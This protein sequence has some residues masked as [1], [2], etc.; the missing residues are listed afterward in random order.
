MGLY[1]DEL[2]ERLTTDERARL[3]AALEQP[4]AARALMA[5]PPDVAFKSERLLAFMTNKDAPQQILF[6]A[7]ATHLRHAP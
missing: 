2:D 4:K 6:R 1:L 3:V 5:L 7:A